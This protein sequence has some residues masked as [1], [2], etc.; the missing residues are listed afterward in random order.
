MFIKFLVLLKGIETMRMYAALYLLLIME[1]HGL[2]GT[3]DRLIINSQSIYLGL[4]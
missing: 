1:I 4:I 3:L 2:V